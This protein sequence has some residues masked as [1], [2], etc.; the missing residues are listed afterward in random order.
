MTP[1]P[2]ACALALALAACASTGPTSV[3]AQHLAHVT[4]DV[5]QWHDAKHPECPFAA[6]VATQVLARDGTSA[7]ERWTV[8]ACAGRRFDYAVSV[9][10]LNGGIWDGVSDVEAPTR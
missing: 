5:Q 8:A 1:R 2:L 3:P 6:V 7:R 4:R 9:K 10:Q